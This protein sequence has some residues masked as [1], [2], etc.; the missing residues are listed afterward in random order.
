MAES[1]MMQ[2]SMAGGAVNLSFDTVLYSLTSSA[3]NGNYMP[4][5]YSTI[6]SYEWKCAMIYNAQCINPFICFNTYSI[7]S[8]SKMLDGGIH[9]QTPSGTELKIMR[10]LD[11]NRYYLYSETSIFLFARLNQSRTDC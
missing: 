1:I 3:S 9:G 7:F 5:L 10:P 6:N 4:Y 8:S 11:V 2:L